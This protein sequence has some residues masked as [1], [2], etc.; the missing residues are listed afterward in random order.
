MTEAVSKVT[1]P[2]TGRPGRNP[3]FSRLNA[4][5]DDEINLRHAYFV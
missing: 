1:K 2:A 4:T 5:V 3:A